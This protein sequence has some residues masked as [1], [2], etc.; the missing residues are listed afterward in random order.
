MTDSE[1]QPPPTPN[2]FYCPQSKW[3]LQITIPMYQSKPITSST[4]SSTVQS[5]HNQHPIQHPQLHTLM[6]WL[7]IPYPILQSWCVMYTSMSDWFCCHF[8]TRPHVIMNGWTITILQPNSKHLCP[9]S[10]LFISQRPPSHPN[11]I[12]GQVRSDQAI[13]TTTTQ[14]PNPLPHSE[15]SSDVSLPWKKQRIQTFIA[16]IAERIALKGGPSDN[17]PT[18]VLS[19]SQI[20]FAPMND[21]FAAWVSLVGHYSFA[22]GLNVYKWDFQVQFPHPTPTLIS[23]WTV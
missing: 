16:N 9:N 12:R 2:H 7:V 22:L 11:C 5:L 10:T 19:W 8:R 14:Q 15:T 20:Q 4:P 18:L 13:P 23:P 17:N 1:Q 6:A 21:C 3:I